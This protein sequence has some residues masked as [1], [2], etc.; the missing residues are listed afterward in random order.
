ME[1]IKKKLYFAL[2]VDNEPFTLKNLAVL[3]QAIDLFVIKY[4]HQELINSL[5]EEGYFVFS[6]DGQWRVCANKKST[7]DYIVLL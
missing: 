3:R 2:L 6:A 4:G 5:R 7:E 1:L